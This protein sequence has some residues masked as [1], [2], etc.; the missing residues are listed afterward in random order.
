[1]ARPAV[2]RQHPKKGQHDES[3]T[4]KC[5]EGEG[6][7]D[8]AKEPVSPLCT[9]C[10]YSWWGNDSKQLNIRGDSFYKSLIE[11]HLSQ[12]YA[13]HRQTQIQAL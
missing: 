4:C 10:S 12:A 7:C 3:H 13:R 8:G 5:G 1:M 6:T 2:E 9:T 11:A